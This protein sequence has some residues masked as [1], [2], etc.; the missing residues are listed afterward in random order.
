MGIFDFLKK[1]RKA[2]APAPAQPSP[3]AAPR[4]TAPRPTE[5]PKPTI[6]FPVAGDAFTTKRLSEIQKQQPTW[7]WIK[8]ADGT[9]QCQSLEQCT[10]NRADADFHPCRCARCGY[11]VHM[12]L[13]P[14]FTCKACGEKVSAVDAVNTVSEYAH[15]A[16][17]DRSFWPMTIRLSSG[18]PAL[19]AASIGPGGT[20]M[21][22]CEKAEYCFCINTTFR[23][24]WNAMK[25]AGRLFP[26]QVEELFTAMILH[27]MEVYQRKQP[28]RN[29]F[30]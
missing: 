26:G 16:V 1:K 18:L 25:A 12:N 29:L 8:D 28:E 10:G 5:P 17:Y 30:A 22:G 13:Q 9:T 20:D 24:R 27:Y 14:D 15:K 3:V 23:E 21:A 7:F 4:L 2:P 11:A 19:L 6:V